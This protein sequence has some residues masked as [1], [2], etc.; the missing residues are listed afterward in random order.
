[1]LI[2]FPFS[3]PFKIIL[4]DWH[5]HVS[6]EWFALSLIGKCT[7]VR[8]YENNTVYNDI[9]VFITFDIDG[10]KEIVL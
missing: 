4:L 6:V 9:Y 8:F 3:T 2:C 5:R 10:N 1:M 7:A